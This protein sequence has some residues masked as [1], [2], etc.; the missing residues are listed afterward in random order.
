VNFTLPAFLA[1]AEGS[2][3][4]KYKISVRNPGRTIVEKRYSSGNDHDP[5]FIN[6]VVESYASCVVFTIVE[7]LVL[8]GY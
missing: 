3:F 4:L 6:A 5:Q 7:K 2:Y 1:L 8:F